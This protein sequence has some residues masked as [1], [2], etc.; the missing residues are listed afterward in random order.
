M[1]VKKI[2]TNKS[3]TTTN[4]ADNDLSESEDHV[5]AN[6][7]KKK[8]KL[9]KTKSLDTVK[10]TTNSLKVDKK[11]KMSSKKGSGGEIYGRSLDQLKLI[12]PEFYKVKQ[13][14]KSLFKDLYYNLLAFNSF[15]SKM[16]KNY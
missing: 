11:S 1:K 13:K 16:I 9:K 3:G 6:P 8:G 12:D 7:E 4:W 2:Q 5:N 14:D 10:G 15:W